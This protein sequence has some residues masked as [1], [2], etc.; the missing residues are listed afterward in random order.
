MKKTNCIYDGP[1]H[2]VKF[3]KKVRRIQVVKVNSG[4]SLS[5]KFGKESMLAYKTRE[6][7]SYTQLFGAGKFKGVSLSGGLHTHLPQKG[8]KKNR[9]KGAKLG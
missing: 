5:S 9:F 8:I 2:R 3:E 7:S 6:E 4:K 1:F